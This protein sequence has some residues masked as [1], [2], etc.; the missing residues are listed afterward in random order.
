MLLDTC[1]N[2]PYT[3]VTLHFFAND[4]VMVFHFGLAMKVSLSRRPRPY[5]TRT[6][7][8]YHPPCS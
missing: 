1:H 5:L 6:L 7:S 2:V 3:K 8:V 4:I